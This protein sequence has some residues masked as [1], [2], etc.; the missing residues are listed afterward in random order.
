M[1]SIEPTSNLQAIA[2]H[3]IVIITAIVA[4][5]LDL[6]PWSKRKG[7]V[8]AVSILGVI[9]AIIVTLLQFPLIKELK[10]PYFFYGMVALDN[11]ALFFNILF[12]IVCGL[13]LLLSSDYVRK[14]DINLGE[15]YALLLL[16]TVGFMF[17]S[18][19]SSL[20]TIFLALEILSLSVYILTGFLRDNLKSN[21]AAFKYFL[22]G[23]FSSALFLYGIAHVYGVVGS[24][25]ISSIALYLSKERS[26][27]NIPF[28]TGLGLMLIG[29]GFKVAVVPFHM[30]TPDVYEGSPTS[31][32][33]FMSVG[34]K[35]ASFAAFVRVFFQAFYPLQTKWVPILWILAALTVII[36]NMTALYQRNIKRMLAYSAI[37]HA[38][39]IL[40]AM[41]AGN[42]LGSS[43]ILYYLLVYSFMNIGAFGVVMIC[44]RREESSLDIASY[45][46]LGFRQP[47]LAVAMT[48]FLVSLAGIPPTGGFVG[49][50][51]VF[52]ATVKAGYIGLTVIAVLASVIAVYY[53]LRIVVYMYMYEPEAD[54]VESRVSPLSSFALI[55]SV[56]GIFQLGLAP[57]TILDLA[58]RSISILLK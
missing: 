10:S 4:L 21:E 52:S 9:V 22:L 42:D 37:A 48:I 13:S 58:Q 28:V 31:V 30:W 14:M 29:F 25:K 53:Y 11:Y 54:F 33:A 51:Y 2:P 24:T 18:S 1:P 15:Y 27:L 36:G 43:S 35:A 8:V 50:F 56:I 19:G 17:M 34:T 55:L 6:I 12:L 5:L 57:A 46:G 26:L 39:Y 3:I 40:M 38:G 23:A 44:E 49:K 7:F 41:V 45:K 20:L 47:L 32:A 16:A